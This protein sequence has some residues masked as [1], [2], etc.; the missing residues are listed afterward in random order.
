MYIM[1]TSTQQC[2]LMIDEHLV[3]CRADFNSISI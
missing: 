3:R 2:A 1:Y